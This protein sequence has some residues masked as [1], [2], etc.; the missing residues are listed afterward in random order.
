MTD[1]RRIRFSYKPLAG[2]RR[3]ITF[4]PDPRYREPEWSWER[5]EEVYDI[6]GQPDTGVWREAGREHVTEPEVV[7]ESEGLTDADREAVLDDA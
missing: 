1:G 5:I 2:P 6:D 7:L 4:Q 3:R